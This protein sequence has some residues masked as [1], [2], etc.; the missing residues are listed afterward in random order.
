MT[1]C[2]TR[3]TAGALIVVKAVIAGPHGTAPARMAVDTGAMLTT[4]KPNM[5]EAVGYTESD[6]I[7]WTRGRTAV[8]EERGYEG[9]SR[10]SPRWGSASTIFG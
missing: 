4:I 9:G 2:E 7:R 10:S 6:A 1:T 3:Y 8:S 5:L